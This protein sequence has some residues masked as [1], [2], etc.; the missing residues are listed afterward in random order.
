MDCSSRGDVI[1]RSLFE[2]LGRF[3]LLLVILCGSYGYALPAAAQSTKAVRVV[4]HAPL[5]VT[6]PVASGAYISRDH[7]YMIYD[8]LVA[9]DENM[10]PRPQMADWTISDDRLTYTFKLRDGL[11]WHDGEP[12]T[13]EDCVASLKRWW[14]RDT[15]GQV[16][17]SYTSSLEATDARTIT[18]K[19]KRPV[20][21]VLDALGK[22]SSY[23]PFMMPRRVADT[24]PTQPSTDTIGSGPFRFV[25]EEFRPGVRAVYVRNDKYVPRT[26]KPSWASG[27]KVVKVDRVEWVVIPDAQTAINA[28]LNGEIDYID[29]PQYDLLKILEGEKNI[30]IKNNNRFGLQVMARM[31][32]LVPPF[33]DEKI[34]R[35]AM[36]AFKQENFLAAMVGDPSGYTICGAMFVCGAPLATDVGSETLIRGNGMAEARR[37]LKEANYDGKPIRIVQ[38]TDVNTQKAQPVVGAQL[39]RQAG[40]NVELLPMDWQTALALRSNPKTAQDGGWNIFFSAF[41]GVDVS[42]PL[43]SLPLNASGMNG[44]PGWAEDADIQALRGRFAEAEDVSERKRLAAELQKLA[45]ERVIYVPLGQIATPAAWSSKLTGVLDGPTVPYF[46]NLEKQ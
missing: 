22:P 12:V 14:Q 1:A 33:N 40:F 2:C 37:L 10:E 11:A 32:F 38:V 8:T 34:R 23:V 26:E 17:A 39:L 18:L 46:W 35:V 6:D 36:L 3:A 20:G 43:S 24:P 15:M 19:L 7:G 13:A 21:F 41:A 4:M 9:L 5:R 27:G 29:E 16:L 25:K 28:L 45:Y 42:N 31:N 30:V 44:Y